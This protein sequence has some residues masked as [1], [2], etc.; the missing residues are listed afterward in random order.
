MRQ[1][2][3]DLGGTNVKWAILEDGLEL[4]GNG[5]KQTH[6]ERGPEQ[7]VL[8]LAEIGQQA[9]A[10]LGPV[11]SVGIG[12]PG[13]YDRANGTARFMT[14]LPGEWAGVP[15]AAPV[16]AELGVPVDLI[17]DA[18]AFALAEATLGAGRG[19]DTVAC[20]TLGT[21]VGGGIVVGG[22]LHEGLDGQA[23]ELGHQTVDSSADAP[24][25]GCGNRGCAEAVY[26]SERQ[27]PDGPD[28]NRVA[29]ALGIAVANTVLTLTPERIVIG[30]GV[31][32]VGET[33]LGPLRRVVAAR[34]RVA[35]IGEIVAAELGPAAGAIGAALRGRAAL[36][37]EA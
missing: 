33:L 26:R 34:V 30:G 21:G 32:R 7:V 3:L 23:G 4:V 28:W 27:R 15:V 22:R 31:A 8:R 29:E 16:S 2:G 20:Y 13:L 10:A 19:Y 35:P 17:N 25:C 37:S 6:G 5:T 12:V 18:R 1:L 11:D 14:N 24:V 36:G 9:I